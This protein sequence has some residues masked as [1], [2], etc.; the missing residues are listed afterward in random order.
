MKK[1]HIVV[2]RT[3]DFDVFLADPIS[4][5][6]ETRWPVPKTARPGDCILFLIPAQHGC[7]TATGEVRTVPVI[8]AEWAGKYE[9]KIDELESLKK[10]IPIGRLQECFAEWGYPR[11]ARGYTTVPEEHVSTLQ[12]MIAEA[13]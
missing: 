13:R 5:G 11:Y 8:S 10:P 12:K 3:T 2:G 1:M 7:I 4:K 6:T 9:C